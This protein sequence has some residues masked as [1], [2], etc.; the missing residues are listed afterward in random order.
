MTSQPLHSWH[1]IPY[2]WHHFQGLWYLVPYTCHITQTMFVNTY[3][4]YFSSNTWCRDNTTTI[5]EITTSI[6]V[7]VWSHRVNPWHNTHCI[8]NMAPTIFMAQYELYMT[9]H[10]RFMTSQHSIH[11]IS[12]LYLISNWLYLTANTLY[13]YHHTQ[14]IDHINPI[15][16]MITQAQYVDII[17]IHMTSHPLFKISHHAMTHTHTV[18]MSSHPG[19]LSSHP[20]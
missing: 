5:S 15:V 2:I 1:Q 20:L 14:I 3:Q 6:C 4:Q 11:Y 9:S 19:Y 12:L 13:L 7:S 8:D 17:W 16:Y 10:P 18:F